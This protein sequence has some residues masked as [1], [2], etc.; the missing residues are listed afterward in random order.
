MYPVREE[1]QILPI[2]SNT[3]GKIIGKERKPIMFLKG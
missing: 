1:D 2:V 3:G